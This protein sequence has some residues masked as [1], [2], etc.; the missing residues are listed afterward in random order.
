M[1]CWP[2]GW[3]NPALKG[4]WDA[5][6]KAFVEQLRQRHDR[7]VLDWG[8]PVSCISWV[9]QLRDQGVQ[10]VWF[11]GDANRAREAVVRRG[12][13]VWEGFHQ[14]IRDIKRAGYPGP[15]NCLVVPALP[16]NGVFLNHHQIESLFFPANQ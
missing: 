1:E 4:V 2:R 6:R 16:Y 5:D 11:D 3:P 7:V 10:L 12:G 15:L 14:Q 9:T 8:F 13:T